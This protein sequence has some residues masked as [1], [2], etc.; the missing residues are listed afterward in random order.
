M[1]PF[2]FPAHVLHARLSV[3]YGRRLAGLLAGRVGNIVV[4]LLVGT[5]VLRAYDDFGPSS[6][7]FC[8][9][10]YG[11]SPPFIYLWQK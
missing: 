7:V 10:F 3:V 8:P 11:S 9:R 6:V 2:V 4:A 1:R 5:F